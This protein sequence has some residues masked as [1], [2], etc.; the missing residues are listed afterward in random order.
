MS[1]RSDTD[2]YIDLGEYLLPD[3]KFRYGDQRYAVRP[4]TKDVGLTL[5]LIATVGAQA[6]SDPA[7]ESMG[8]L[9]ASQREI[10]AS[11]RDA[12][13]GELTL[14]EDVYRQ[15]IADGVPGPHIDTYALYALYY[16]VYRSKDLADE[17]TALSAGKIAPKA[18]A[19][20][21]SKS[22][23]STASGS[24]ST[25]STRSRSTR[26][27]RSPKA[28][29]AAA[30]SSEASPGPESGGGKSSPTGTSS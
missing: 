11:V 12:D 9:S 30:D 25:T 5:T 22:G 7:G 18:T 1:T 10:L 28:P 27:T 26:T 20:A 24:R 14:G 3:L 16:W 19:P 29:P 4:P 13:L 17:M 8:D 21:R 15:M 23:R 2:G 6:L